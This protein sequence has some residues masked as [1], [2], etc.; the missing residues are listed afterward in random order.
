MVKLSE[1]VYDPIVS[2]CVCVYADVFLPILRNVSN[3]CTKEAI[4]AHTHTLAHS[5]DLISSKSFD[6]SSVDVV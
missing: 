6:T 5:L 2:E 1:F 4:C 3:V